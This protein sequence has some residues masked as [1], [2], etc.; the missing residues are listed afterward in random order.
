VSST[1]LLEGA[2]KSF[3]E[4]LADLISSI[5]GWELIV[6]D[7]EYLI[8][9]ESD[10][11]FDFDSAQIREEAKKPLLQFANVIAT[12]EK[13]ELSIS[14]HTDSKGSDQYNDKL[15]LRRADSVKKFLDS[16]NELK[17]WALSI[18]GR[19]ERDPIAPNTLPDGDDNPQGRQKNRR[20]ELRLKKG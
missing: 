15:S 6:E 12:Y 18:Q 20:V 13:K 10:I 2:V 14:G 16:S 11:L 9:M 7:F 3:R 1:R 8:R 5:K 4:T 19:G 17:G